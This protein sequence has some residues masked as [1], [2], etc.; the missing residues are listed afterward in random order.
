MTTAIFGAGG[1]VGKVV[2]EELARRKMPVRLVGRSVERLRT[3]PGAPV[4]AMRADFDDPDSIRAAAR[5]VETIVYAAGAPYER[6]ALHPQRM[7]ATRA[8]ARAEG[9]SRIILIGTVYPYGIP[10]TQPVD[11]SHPREPHTFKGRMRK[12]QEDLVFAA[13]RAGEIRGLVLRVPDFYGPGAELSLVHDCFRAA[14]AGKR[15]NLIGP[16]DFPHQFFYVSDL[17]PVVSDL[18]ER[19]EAFGD[20]YNVA[21]AETITTRAFAERVFARAGTKPSWFVANKTV[22]RAMGIVNPLM[23]ELVE[24]NYLQTSPVILDD[25][26]LSRVLGGMHKTSYDEGIA[27]TLEALRVAG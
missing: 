7:R 25:T 14:A 9:V 11:E 22:L 17:A 10:T 5:G 6:F 4:T 3:V 26:K 19:D 23:R 24:M 13:D 21:P 12:E 2:A 16:I 1:A 8:A 27:Q 18:L 20:A 15:A